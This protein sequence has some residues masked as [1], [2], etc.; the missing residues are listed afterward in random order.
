M[1]SGYG[2]VRFQ[3]VAVRHILAIR[4]V[5]YPC[6]GSSIGRGLPSSPMAT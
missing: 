5:P 6:A 2:G 3:A 1:P 4:P